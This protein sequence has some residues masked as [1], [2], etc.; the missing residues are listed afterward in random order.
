MSTGLGAP[1]PRERDALL[2]GDAERRAVGRDRA[3]RGARAAH[4]R[5]T[6]KAVRAALELD[7]RRR[8]GGIRDGAAVPVRGRRGGG[9][10]RDRAEVRERERAATGAA[11]RRRRL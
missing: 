9:G 4:G 1:A 10:E 8:P 6:A 5:E 7:R 2:P 11:A 3:R